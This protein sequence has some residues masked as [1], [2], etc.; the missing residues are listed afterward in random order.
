M[1][2]KKYKVVSP[3]LWNEVPSFR[4]STYD[5]IVMINKGVGYCS[6]DTTAT[7]LRYLG[8]TVTEII[9]EDTKVKEEDT[10][11][12]EEKVEDLG[13][14]I[15]DQISEDQIIEDEENN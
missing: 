12:K 15:E 6:H 3:A 8:Y 10:K 1:K 9:E 4:E 13:I 5:E 14:I 7:K 2:K 11:V